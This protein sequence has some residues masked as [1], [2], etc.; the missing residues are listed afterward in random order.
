FEEVGKKLGEDAPDDKVEAL[1]KEISEEVNEK[2]PNYKRIKKVV[3]RKEEFEKN[4]SKKIK[5]Y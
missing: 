5:R 4:T 2:L 3:L 1:L